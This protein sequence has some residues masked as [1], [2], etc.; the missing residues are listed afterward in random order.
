MTK[1]VALAVAT[2]LVVVLVGPPIAAYAAVGP[3]NTTAQGI[4]ATINLLA[5]GLPLTLALPNPAR[6]W[7][8]GQAD[9]SGNTLGATL[10]GGLLPQLLTVGA[11]NT[12]VGAAAPGGGR[13]QAGTAG[14]NVLGAV[15]TGAIQTTCQMTAAGITTTTDVANLTV[16]GANV[17]PDANVAINVPGVLTGTIDHRIAAYNA[18]TGRLDYTVRAV[19]LDLLGGLAVVASGSVVVAESTC[20]GIVKLGAVNLAAANLAPGETGTPRVTVTNTGDIAAPNTTIRIPVPPAGYTLGTPTVTG[21][22]SCSVTGGFVVCTGVTV[23][24]SGSVAVS[25]PVSLAAS[26]VTA[27]DWAPAANTITA[28]STPIAAVTGT[29]ITV[30]GGGTLVN[31]QPA[32]STGGLIS[33]NPI[34]LAAGKQA[35]AT[36]TVTNDGPSDATTTVTIPLDGR[37]QGVSV[38][39]ATAGGNPCTVTS[40]AITCTGVTVPGGGSTP[41]TVRVAAT[42]TTPPTTVWNLAGLTAILNGTAITGQGRL[43]TVSD[44]DVNLDNGVTVTPV[45]V[46]PGG[47]PA[48]LRVTV[49]NVGIIPA[50]GTTITLPAPPAGYT[51]GPVTTTGGGTCT[52]DGT[53]VRCTGVTVPA[54]GSVVVSVPVRL[55]AGVTAGWTAA[56]GAP[57]TASSGDSTGTATGTLVTADPTWTLG[58]SAT[59]PADR[60]VRPGQTATMTVTVSD[61]G[62]SDARNASYIV[63][64][65][66]NTTFGPLTGAA[67]A[68]TQLSPTAL[69]CTSDI[70][71][72]GPAVTLTLPLAVAANADPAVPLTG[73]CVSLDNNTTCGDTGD[74]ALPT[75]NLRTP[76]ANRLTVTTTQAT[77]VPGRDGTARVRLTS[78]QD[79]DDLTVTIPLADLPS[80]F[81]VTGGDCTRTGTAI[82]C[83]GVDLTAG[84]EL[85]I[86]LTVAVAANVTPPAT[87]TATGITVSD[88]G[89]E[90]TVTGALATAGTPV[91]ALGATVT[92]PADNTV[93]PGQT[94]NLGLTV[95]NAGPSDA[96]ATAFRVL[97]PT[98][99]TLG[100]PTGAAATACQVTPGTTTATCTVTLAAGASSPQLTLPVVVPAGA[101]VATPL[102]GGCV[103]L[104]NDGSCGPAPD[105]AFDPIMLKVPFA[106]QVAVT[107]TPVTVTPGTT[108]TATVNVRAT[109][110]DVSG[111]TV[112]VPLADLPTG[113]TVTSAGDC[114]VTSTTV[115]CT[116]VSVENGTTTP[117]RLTVSVPPGV[118]QGPTWTATGITV[119]QGAEQVTA[120][121]PLATIGAPQ[122]TLAT[123]FTPPANGT[124]IPGGTG[125]LRVTVDNEGPSDA[126]GA[127]VAV[128]APTGTTLSNGP[129]GCTIAGDGRSATC[130]V[131]LTAAAAP[132]SYDFDLTVSAQADADDVVEGGCYDIDANGLCDPGEPRIPDFWLETPLADI[133]TIGT[134][135][136][137][138]APGRTGT[139]TVT[140]TATRPET[141]LDVTI[142]LTDLP[143]GFRVTAATGCAVGAAS[144]TCDDVDLKKDEPLALALTVAVGAA[145]APGTAWA[146]TGI[147]VTNGPEHVTADGTLATAGPSQATVTAVVTPPADGTVAAGGTTSLALVVS[148]AGPSDVTGRSFTVTAPA[149]TTFGT[150][151]GDAAT[152]CTVAGDARSL[153]CSVT[154]AAGTSTPELALPL[155]VDVNADPF[156][157]VAGGC[158]TFSGTTDCVAIPEFDLSVPLDRRARILTTPTT[159]T[160]GTE[161]PVTVGVQSQRGDLSGLTLVIPLAAVPAS[162]T[163]T[164]VA[165][166]CTQTASE[167]RCTGI[168]VTD[169]STTPVTALRVRATAAAAQGTAWTATGIVLDAGSDGQLTQDGQLAVVG[170]PAATLQATVDGPDEPIL[171]G[172]TGTLDITLD[173][174][175]PSD[176]PTTTIGFDAPTGSTIGDLPAPTGAICD[177][178]PGAT[179]LTC[180]FGLPADADPIVV[181]VPI[182][183]APDADPRRPLTG[184]CVDLDNNRTCSPPD[185]TVPPVPLATPFAQQVALSTTPV[186]VTP[187]RTGVARV[188]VTTDPAQTGLT[189]TVP[190][191]GLPAGVTIGTPSVAPGGTCTGDASTIRCTGVDIAAGGAATVSVPLAVS[192]AAPAATWTATGITVTNGAGAS[193]SA[194][195]V[196]LRTGAASF[197]LTGTTRAPAEGT[198]LP[199]GTAAIDL[200]LD[201]QGPSDAVDAPVAVTAPVGTTFGPLS[202]ATAEACT[203]TTTTTLTCRVNLAATSE[204]LVLT[205][206]VVIPADA[207]PDVRITGG[208]ADLDGTGACGG[209]GDVVLP[210]L[211]LRAP[212]AGVV[213]VTSTN[214]SITPG[215][216]GTATITVSSSQPRPGSTV[217]LDTSALPAGLTLTSATPCTDCANVDL[218]VTLTL[219]L[220]AAPDAAQATWTPTVTVTDGTETATFTP[221]AARIGAPV[222]PLTVAVDA[223]GPGTVPPGGTAELAVT[224]TNEGPSLYPGARVQFKAPTG[225]TFA[226]L[227][228]PAAGFCTAATTLVTCAA[229]LPAG[230]RVFTLG[231]LVPGTADP[232]VVLDDGCWD[233]NLDG[234]CGGAPDQPLPPVELQ[235]PLGAAATLTVEAGT[236]VPGGDPATGTVVVTSTQDLT[237]LTL[238]VPTGTLPAG[239]TITGVAPGSCTSTGD[240]V[241]TGLA[242]TTGRNEVVRVT[243]RAS[244]A[245]AAGVTWNPGQITLRNAAGQQAYGTGTLITTGPPVAPIVYDAT[246]AAAGVTPG[247]TA[248][249]TVTADNTGPSDAVNATTS[250]LAPT[251]TTFGPLGGQAAA[252]CTP[253]GDRRLDCRFDLTAA[254]APLVWTIPLVVNADA[255]PTTTLG[256]GC[257]DADGNGVCGPTEEDL[258]GIPLTRTL[259]Q[260]ITV[261]ADNVAIIPGR[262]GTA[263][264]TVRAADARSGL[265]VTIPLTGL[266]AGVTVTGARQ[267][268]TTDCIVGTT[269]VT[270]TGI[271]LAAGG[272]TPIAL[273]VTTTAAATAGAT[274]TPQVSVTQGQI[275]VV[276]P[277]TALTV[278]AAASTLTVTVTPPAPGTVLPGADS[279]LAVAVANSGPSNARARVLTFR[280]PQSTTF[281]DPLPAFCTAADPR[282]ATCTVD[283]DAAATLRFTLPIRVAATAGGGTTL[284]D[285]CVDTGSGCTT[286]LP[287]IVLG[288]PL[289]GRVQLTTRDAT[290][291]PGQTGIAYVRVV[292]DRAVPGATVTVPLT[293]LPAGLTVVSAAGPTGSVCGWTGEVRCTGV[294]VAAGTSDPVALLI[295][296]TAALRA[297]VTWTATG[298]TLEAG[299]ETATGSGRLAV[300]GTPVAPLTA[301]VT[302][303]A[304]TVLPGDVTS[305]QITVTNPGPSDATGVTATVTAPTNSTFGPLSGQVALDCGVAGTTTLTCSFG[306]TAGTSRT[307]TIPVLVDGTAANGDRVANGCVTVAGG[308][309]VCGGNALVTSLAAGR[310][311][312]ESA[313]LAV[314]PVTVTPGSSGTATLRYTS[315]ASYDDLTLT[316]PLS[317]KPAGMTVTG[318]GTCVVGATAITC[319]GLSLAAG[320]PLVVTLP[321]ALSGTATGTWNQTG[322]TL[323]GDAT[324]GTL[325]SAATLVTAGP[326][327]API[328]YDSSVAAAGVTPGGTATLTVTADN[329]G[330]SDAVNATTSILAPTGTTFGALTGQAS[331]DCA[332]ADNRRLTCR[333]DL[334]AAAAPLV[335][336][337]P[338]IVNADAD[339]TTTLGDGCVDADGNGVCGPTEEDVPGIPL[340]RTLDQAITVTADTIAIIPGRTGTATVTVRAADARSG[341]TVTIPLSGLPAGVTVTGATPAGCVVGAT[342]VTCSDITLAA[343]AST[344]IALAVSATAAAVTGSAWAPQ[345]GVRQGDVAVTRPVTALT[346]GTATSTVT[347]T[348][349]GPTG[350]VLPGDVTSTQITVTNSGPS[351]AAAV[352]ATVTAPTNS[353]FGT[354]AGQVALDCNRSAATTLT[355][356]FAQAA[357]TSR[358]W[359]VPVVVSSTASN[360][361]P[362]ANGCV[363]V[364]GSPAV[365]GG[366]ATVVSFAADRPLTGNVTTAFTPATVAAGDS[367]PATIRFTSAIASYDDLTLTIPL[368]GKPAGMT[369]T[370]AN[371]GGSDCTIGASAITCTGLTLAAGTP[372]TITVAVTL[373]STVTTGTKW[374]PTG[375]LLAGDTT[376]GTLSSSGT[377]VTATAASYNVTVTVGAPTVPRPAPGQTT[378]LP[379]TLSNSGPQD[380]NPYVA[381]IVLPTNTTAGTLPDGCVPGSGARLVVCTLGIANGETTQIDLPLVVSSSAAVGS[382][383]SGGCV[384][385][386]GNGACG[387]SDDQALPTFTVSAPSVDLNIEYSNPQPKATKGATLL[388]KLPYSNNGTTSA[389][390][391]SFVI[392]PPAGTTLTKAAVLLDATAAGFTAQATAADTIELACTAA[393]DVD[394]NAVT[395][396]GPEAP[397][398]A[399]SELWL[400][401]AVAKTAKAG[402]FPVNVTI[403]TTSAE[404]NTVNNTATASLTIAGSATDSDTDTSD[405]D[406]S[407]SDG[408][409]GTDTPAGSG[410]NGSGNLP[411]TGQDLTGLILLAVLLVVGG[412][413][414][415]IGARTRRR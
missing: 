86:P 215:T 236:A 146:V 217:R 318:A 212:L 350:D 191:A 366:N 292:A 309:P 197:T 407:N 30:R 403:S 89:E 251:G 101:D 277:V 302:G 121:G 45:T 150:L 333:F 38:V 398:G 247:G 355:C 231:L 183:V 363:T 354:L 184:G 234:V 82:T 405:P 246:V 143:A 31:R 201:N 128:I 80:G 339:P 395:C 43:L 97:A 365:C 159:V 79:E 132:I 147:D 224:L 383:I 396:T 296:A 134:T 206:P 258:P 175:G 380:A 196:L 336:E 208:C 240:I 406:D 401:L 260:A 287:E 273:A 110:G 267:G 340:T 344:G 13:A 256:D 413:V 331:Q 371:A 275:A 152:A 179:R 6:T 322:I 125:R 351:D 357:G 161:E 102:G 76:I 192:S 257:V 276:R 391:V 70:P 278:G 59:G 252:D 117:I 180:T 334:T 362:V 87:W 18:T 368:A 410:S 285:G 91:Y 280:A 233:A 301:T 367:G 155:A 169:G 291:V 95:R 325:T 393:P 330:P 116:D 141:D 48:T 55:A 289:S 250:I 324:A 90:L 109:H 377:L 321:V 290:V 1:R 186:T 8:T 305:T 11:V 338:L 229:D 284:G 108:G 255:D 359:T 316:I 313:T 271:T 387:S 198:V 123:T 372:L 164:A 315:T 170:A 295:R 293:S 244:G 207:D 400:Y 402:T 356:R 232:D 205:L 342:A 352:T 249:L 111:L 399:S 130:P 237:G 317:G 189:V 120:D 103:D 194:D 282:A 63:V 60:T 326:P 335:W 294:D 41:I 167:V 126:T 283:V 94:T 154:L 374:T 93:E 370:G 131:T 62:P 279:S 20:S 288:T 245:A 158:V 262:T 226:P 223:P 145:V 408:D 264:V 202:G 297:G 270:C 113:M 51:F 384:D 385:G 221:V 376:A 266:P 133:V 83:T 157:P 263:T 28:V 204:P 412:A 53:G 304:G 214:P 390:D 37:P 112:T 46:I 66:Q 381:T 88:G 138:I 25:L 47:D 327:V 137:T 163:V 81:T 281:I 119:A 200:V 72:A 98:G 58:V 65:P 348:V 358:T 144:I 378:V 414:A 71:V 253:A 74:V 242:L 265:T 415:R 220:T 268:G 136:A 33:V 188:T 181:A 107:T 22:G 190:L 314:T 124:L 7:T 148:N 104:D 274:W 118:A 394:A 135:S 397:V 375:V 310:G 219:R 332:P 312:Q 409:T 272:S 10:G 300:T 54:T 211:A 261:T 114:T 96:P 345:V 52:A 122:F 210:D 172:G 303:P 57:V 307:W 153:T 173:N 319:T 227:G 213:T 239:L 73:G 337:I 364:S 346:V 50:T 311:L 320:T 343:G 115:T 360:G 105:V 16:A 193:R 222:H 299:G 69:R 56:A 388:L 26:A 36:I 140:L 187:G 149:D 44:P 254:A 171:P 21:G 106:Q 19:D 392:D 174:A 177:T 323:A 160:P 178:E 168:D 165:P 199:G 166:G 27:A 24:G 382:T 269:D 92:G 195:G 139:A 379:I 151:S 286:D 2:L 369:V 77:I 209:T 176:L 78:T 308:A 389:A 39:S 248:T 182:V 40:T 68:C 32:Y 243:A 241:C 235:T 238:T 17:N 259:D 64:A 15:T 35:N 298:I 373:A 14:L 12:A 329:T 349:T 9:S 61:R 203:A 341:L 185:V 230:D 4:R 306:Q 411:K 49:R 127:S 129:A 23:P 142:P 225:T 75:V 328:V 386:G 3:V 42:T 404:G 361:D 156:T 34:S 228:G 162:L 100:T 29:T 218:P 84:R 347:A 5:G 67:A 99:T 353:T 85:V 216:T